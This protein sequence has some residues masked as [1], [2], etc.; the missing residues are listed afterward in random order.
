MQ[1]PFLD[2]SLGEGTES[3]PTFISSLLSEEQ[4]RQ[5]IVLLHEFRDYDEMPGLDR[6]F[7]DDHFDL[8]FCDRKNL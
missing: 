7:I 2:S 3:Q 4:Q 8:A 6:K 5:L 1:D